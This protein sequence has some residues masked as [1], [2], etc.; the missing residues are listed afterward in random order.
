M[1]ALQS[2]SGLFS[3][4]LFDYFLDGRSMGY[5]VKDIVHRKRTLE[6]SREDA[7]VEI[8]IRLTHFEEF[9]AQLI[10]LRAEFIVELCPFF[11]ITAGIWRRGFG[12]RHDGT[13]STRAS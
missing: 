9:F 8:V 4:Q 10:T 2:S 13:F 7:N 1:A 6:F 12:W 3:I 11:A 5:E